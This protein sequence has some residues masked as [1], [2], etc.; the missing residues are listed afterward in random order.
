V[1]YRGDIDGLRAIAVLAVVI[2]HLEVVQFSGGYVGVD[3]FFV[4]SGYLI[5]SIIKTKYDAGRFSF[6]DFYF[7]RIRRLIPPLI[8]TVI[9]TVFGAAFILTPDD[10][11]AF[12]RSA[13]AALFSVSN[14][15][16]Y[17][18]AGYWDTA[19]ELKPLLH[20]W[21]LGVEEQF[22]LF[23]PAMTVAM[24]AMAARVPLLFSLSTL[25]VVGAALCVWYSYVDLSAAFYLFP[26]RVFQF[27]AGA[28]VIPLSARLMTRE[29]GAHRVLLTSAGSL[30]LLLIA[31]SV[32]LLGEHT[33]FPG[34]YILVPTVG[35]V[36]VLLAGATVRADWRV[37]HYLL[38][39]RASL[40]VGRAS[41]SMYLVHWPIIALYRYATD[42]ELSPLEQVGL[43]VATLVA[44]CALHYGVER[45]FYQRNVGVDSEV[46]AKPATSGRFA[47]A[48]LSISCIVAIVP[49][50]AWLGDGWAVRYSTLSLSPEAI[51]RGKKDRYLN[52]QKAC[53]VHYER[54][55][56]ACARD[57]E[58]QV[59]IL[60]NSHV[61][62]AFNFLYGAFS[63]NKDINIVVF[64][65]INLCKD[66][67]QK[68][69][70]FVSSA[71]VCQ[72]RLDALFDGGV[73][74]DMQV[75]LYGANRPYL[76][77]KQGILELIRAVQSANP[78]ASLLT[79]GGYINTRVPC[80]RL[81]NET[82]T[83]DSCA[84]PENVAYFAN[85][86]EQA[87]LYEQ[88]AAIEDGYIDRVELLCENR[89]VETCL[90]RTGEGTPMFYDRHH[91]SRQFAEMTGRMY[92]N[93]YPDFL[94]DLVQ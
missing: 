23:W 44:T 38:E 45:R 60:G 30:G 26:F 88:F 89:I 17:A 21:S 66:L 7:R 40:W 4:I 49:M 73:A 90:T 76:S 31:I 93:K 79:Y 91:L 52:Y 87:P 56:P 14:F 78:G 61:P 2:F 64:G 62:D 13:V 28:L 94:Y 12:G 39:S 48:V 65:D 15:V 18:E 68:E 54:S 63:E 80:A 9:A 77:N 3:V 34:W 36:L 86:P 57:A 67:A 59:L 84:L 25:V 81:V 24:L 51:E 6:G 27:A 8:V 50:T 42:V 75:I 29:G 83:T 20:T 37:G 71:P 82:Q 5:T 47:L 92:F 35:S 32:A 22:Y 55:H 19:S 70:R 74:A 43:G 58:I 1:N 33:S 16:F 41:Y 53:F 72:E 85:H 69:G 46:K 11:M 10:M